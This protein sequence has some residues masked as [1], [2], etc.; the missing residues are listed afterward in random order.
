MLWVFDHHL[1]PTDSRYAPKAKEILNKV[2]NGWP[3]FNSREEL[4][5][6]FPSNERPNSNF[7]TARRFLYLQPVSEGGVFLP[8][9]SVYCDFARSLPEVRIRMALYF[10]DSSDAIKACGYRFEAPEGPGRH[11]YYHVQPIARFGAHELPGCPPWLSTKQPTFA[12]DA[13]DAVAMVLCVLVSLYGIRDVQQLQSEL[14]GMLREVLSRR[15]WAKVPLPRYWQVSS[16]SGAPRAGQPTKSS[17][18]SQSP[19][20]SRAR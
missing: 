1:K 4:D 10:L 15:N 14:G 17:D 6:H 11:N 13:D 16:P 18:R 20:T 7:D 3:P 2:S 8:I 5:H 12:L 19:S 9:L